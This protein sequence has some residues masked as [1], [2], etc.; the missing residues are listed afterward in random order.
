MQVLSCV[1]TGDDVAIPVAV[2]A[3]LGLVA[4]PIAA[5]LARWLVP[6][7]EAGRPVTWAASLGCSVV[8]ASVVGRYG[9][10]AEALQMTLFSTVLVVVTLTDLMA[11][12]IPNSCVAAAA[13]VRLVLLVAR[14]DAAELV[15]FLLAAL[16]VGGFLTL[17]ALAMDAALGRRSLGGGDV[18]LLAVAALYFGLSRTVF[19]LL[20]ACALGLLSGIGLKAWRRLVA[21]GDSGEGENDDVPSGAFPWGPSIA[22]ACW[23]TMLFGDGAIA[24]YLAA[25]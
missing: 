17:L 6:A 8:F 15:S 23:M 10:T 1:A 14:G 4:G 9:A 22:I 19:L 7:G 18:K 11:Y 5:A 25:F 16:A 3:L 24:L 12:T 21:G 20:V 2:A 13:A